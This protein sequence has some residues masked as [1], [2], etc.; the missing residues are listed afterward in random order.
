MLGISHD[1]GYAPFLDEILR[2]EDTKSRVTILEGVPTVRELKTTGVHIFRMDNGL[3]R[4]DKIGENFAFQGRTSPTQTSP[5]MSSTNG[6]SQPTPP[7]SNHT[8]SPFSS[9][10]GM[11]VKAKPVSPPPQVTVPLAPRSGNAG[12]RQKPTQPKWNPG[13]RGLDKAIN[14]NPNVLESVKKRKD[15]NKLCNNHFLR[16]PCSKGDACQFVHKYKP[17]EEE[18]QAILYLSRMN[19]CTMGQDCDADDCIY[20]H[21]V[22]FFFS[23][24]NYTVFLLT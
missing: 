18:L 4:N 17:T 6:S 23:L 13:P 14:V 5:R 3:F 19:P 11:A 22:S 2:D 10:A 9:Y 7:A 20:G 8:S 21:H 1:S 24:V 15:N 12:P 16:G